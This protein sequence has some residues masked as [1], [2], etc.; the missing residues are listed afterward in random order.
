[1]KE[2]KR[3]QIEILEIKAIWSLQ[4]LDIAE[5]KISQ[6]EDIAIESIQ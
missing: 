3:I 2:L 4:W 1:M 6:L 5:E